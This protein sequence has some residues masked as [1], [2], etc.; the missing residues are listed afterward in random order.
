MKGYLSVKICQLRDV[1]KR[2][3]RSTQKKRHAV[4][5]TKRKYQNWK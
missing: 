3:N 5:K 1:P 2:G 4:R